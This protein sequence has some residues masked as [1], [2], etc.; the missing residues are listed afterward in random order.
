MHVDVLTTLGDL[1]RHEAE[2][3]RLRLPS[4]MQ[5]PAWLISWWEAYGEDDPSCELATLAVRDAYDALVGLAPC[6]VRRRPVVGP[7]LRMLGDGRASTDHHTV[8]CREPELEPGVVNAVAEWIV[9][10]AG[11]AWRR[12]RFEAIDADDRAMSHLERLFDEA[13]LD[14]Q[15]IDDLGSFPADMAAHED[16]PTW[17]NYLATLSKNRRKRLRRWERE[18]FETGRAVTRV[19]D[20]EAE[21]RELWPELVRLHRERRQAMG[22]QGVFDEPRF[23]RFHRLASERL[24]AQGAIHLTMLELDGEPAAV[25]Y[26]LRDA[27]TLYAYQGGIAPAALEKDAGHLS[28]MAMAR[29][30]LESGRTRLD[31]LRGDELY[32][33]SWGALHRPAATL[34]VRPRDAAGALERWVGDTY[35]MWRDRGKPTPAE[36]LAV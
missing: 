8:L 23:D 33:L 29:T 19:A 34:H 18:Q 22:Y 28:L 20:S 17:D 3:S 5:S 35:R 9:E 21:R 15:R 36:E 4:P 25:D 11:H 30:A 31:L 32:K 27:T 26:A 16:E 6:Y 1:R 10:S 12:I 2:W 14:T 24:F 7:T 13:G